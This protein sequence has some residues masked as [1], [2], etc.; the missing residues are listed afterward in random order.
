MSKL[1]TVDPDLIHAEITVLQTRINRLRALLAGV[2]ELRQFSPAAKSKP[3]AAN[4]RGRPRANPLYDKIKA[5]VNT[6]TVQFS[7]IDMRRVAPG[8]DRHT[9][10]AAVR[11]LINDGVLV[12]DIPPMGRRPGVYHRAGQN[13]AA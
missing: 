10:G 2:E 12:M 8:K 13:G 3:D 9:F 7:N 6:Q 5:F 4:G 11:A 1:V